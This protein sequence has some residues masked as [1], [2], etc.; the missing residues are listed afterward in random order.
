MWMGEGWPAALPGQDAVGV[1]VQGRAVDWRRLRL[2][3]KRS[4]KMLIVLDEYSR[5]ALCRT[6][7]IGMRPAEALEESFLPPLL[8]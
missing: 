3:N 7:R 1:A 8:N 5:E 4:Y 2:S 6:V